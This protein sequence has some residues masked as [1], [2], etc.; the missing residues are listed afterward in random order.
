MTDSKKIDIETVKEGYA[1]GI[2]TQLAVYG[3]LTREQKENIIDEAAQKFGEFL[4]FC[5]YP[6]KIPCFMMHEVI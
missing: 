3:E 2:S 1:N 6:T 5:K 4:T